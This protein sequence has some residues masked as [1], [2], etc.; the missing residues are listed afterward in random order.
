MSQKVNTSKSQMQ[1]MAKIILCE[2]YGGESAYSLF[3]PDTNASVTQAQLIEALSTQSQML[4][5]EREFQSGEE[6]AERYA[7]AFWAGEGAPRLS[8]KDYFGQR[9]G[10]K[11]G[12]TE[13][14][15]QTAHNADKSME[16][17]P[18]AI[19]N[20]GLVVSGELSEKLSERFCRDA[21]RY[22]GAYERY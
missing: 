14:N 2:I 4:R 13:T 20:T 15:E 1:E 18:E 6:N 17:Y 11:P 21:R 10:R 12:R 7:Q 5:M 9:F 3:G 22:D 19:Q 8:R 16:A